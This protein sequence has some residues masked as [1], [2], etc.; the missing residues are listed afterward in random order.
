[1]HLNMSKLTAQ[2]CQ[3][4]LNLQSEIAVGLDF[5]P[6]LRTTLDIPLEWLQDR[7]SVHGD[8]LVLDVQME[9]IKRAIL[10]LIQTNAAKQYV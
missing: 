9:N 10:E 3:E 6:K 7:S 4:V 1:M 5:K 2:E 8:E